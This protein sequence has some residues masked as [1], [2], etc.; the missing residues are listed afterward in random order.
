MCGRDEERCEHVFISGGVRI[1]S[2]CVRAAAAQLDAL[3][4]DAPRLVRYRRPEVAPS[5]KDD[6]IDAIERA[7]DAVIGPL[8]LAVDDALAFCEGGEACR[9]LLDV[10]RAVGDR[11]PVV[12]NDQTVERVRFLGED[13]AEVSVGIWLAGNPQEF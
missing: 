2:D 12:I 13:E 6:A 3:P 7:F 1:C 4:P 8:A 9:E 10:I 11:V 5:D